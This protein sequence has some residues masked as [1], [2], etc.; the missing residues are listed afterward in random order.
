MPETG[1]G[2]ALALAATTSLPEAKVTTNETWSIDAILL[3]AKGE[4]PESEPEPQRIVVPAARKAVSPA[5]LEIREVVGSSTGRTVIPNSDR[6]PD[7]SAY[8][9]MRERTG[10]VTEFRSVPQEGSPT[11][12]PEPSS[13]YSVT[14]GKDSL[15]QPE[16]AQPQL[17]VP[18]GSL[19]E[20][21][22][23]RGRTDGVVDLYAEYKT[24]KVQL[25]TSR[26][27]GQVMFELS[28]FHLARSVPG[29]IQKPRQIEENFVGIVF[30]GEMR[31]QAALDAHTMFIALGYDVSIGS[32]YKGVIDRLSF[33]S[34]VMIKEPLSMDEFIKVI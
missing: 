23:R 15:G 2:S 33:K 34:L 18:S 17:L 10:T 8:V 29:F 25:S 27:F 31:Q 12:V 24:T 19:K 28:E 3:L 14:A 20:A 9:A 4:E 6:F 32:P 11:S 7:L 21:G 5:E 26:A 22:P 13:R 30:E 16:K 1:P